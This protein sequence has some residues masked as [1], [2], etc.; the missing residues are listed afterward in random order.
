MMSKQRKD[1]QKIYKYG[2]CVITP[3]IDTKDNPRVNLS[4]H[5]V[6]HCLYLDTGVYAFVL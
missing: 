6:T 2:S 1:G 5:S 4:D 3:N